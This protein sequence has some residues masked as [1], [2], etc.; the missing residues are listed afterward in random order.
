MTDNKELIKS[1]ASRL[2]RLGGLAGRVGASMAG[3]S[4]A[5]LFRDTDTRGDHRAVMLMKNALRIKELLGE[6]KGVP[7]KIGQ[8]ISLHENLFPREVVQVL[9][10]LQQNAPPV[11]FSDLRAM[12]EKEL[13]PRLGYIRHID[14][15]PMA[16]AS[17]GQ[18]HRAVLVNGAPVALKIQYPGI[19]TVIRADLKNLKGL[20]KLLFSMFSRMDMEPV[21]QELKDRLMEELDYEQEAANIKRMANLYA[22]DPRIIIPRVVDEITSRHI[23]GMELVLGI[24]PDAASA[25]HYPQTLKNEWGQTLLHLILKGL[26]QFRFLHADPNIANFSFLEDGRL[27]VYDFG[28]MKEIPDDLCTGYA[29]LVR[30]FLAENHGD[31]PDILKCMGVH[32]AD[33]EVMTAAMAADFLGV[34]QEFF[35]PESHYTFG[36]DEKIYE[37]IYALGNK[38]MSESMTMVFPKDIVFVDRTFSGHFGNLCCLNARADW[39]TILQSYVADSEKICRPPAGQNNRI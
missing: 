8:M 2:F 38:H 21:W 17:I 19:D 33:G 25:N 14:E 24:P 37:R 4:L 15:T 23:L 7:M 35:H 36:S 6:L 3:N 30:A 22:D 1:A 16:A 28:C 9:K 13:G 5:N 10:S 11:P 18:V 20:L 34:L 27:I 29:Q 26:F 31:I 39:R 12:M 32:R